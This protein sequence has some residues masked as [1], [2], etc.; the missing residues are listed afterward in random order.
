[1]DD[2]INHRFRGWAARRCTI[3]AN[4]DFAQLLP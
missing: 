1:V 2:T 4:L 3:E